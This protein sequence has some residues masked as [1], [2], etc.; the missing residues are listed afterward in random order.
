[1]EAIGVGANVLAFILLGLKSAKFIHET[2][3]AVKDGPEIVQRV[4]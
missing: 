2:L 1:M 4:V 3:S